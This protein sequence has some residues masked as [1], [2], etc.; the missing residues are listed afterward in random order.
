MKMTDLKLPKEKT[1]GPETLAAPGKPENQDRWP[2]GMRLRFESEQCDKMLGLKKMT[3]GEKVHIEGDGEIISVS[4]N[5]NQGGKERYSV[6]VQ[7]Q[8]VGV[9]SKDSFDQSYKESAEEDK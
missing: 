8:K 3:V 7:V 1:K 2:Y 4:S 9:D 6:E 5:Q